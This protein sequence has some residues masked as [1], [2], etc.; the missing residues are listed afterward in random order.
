MNPLISII[1][2]VYNG[3]AY[4]E[5]CFNSILKQTHEN[6]EIIIIND[7]SKDSSPEIC[8]KFAELDNRIKLV[9]QTNRGLSSVRNKGIEMAS[10]DLIGF[11]DSDD[12]I[13]PNMYE[14]LLNNLRDYEA[15]IA[16]CETTKVYDTNIN[17]HI[18][19][20]NKT[21]RKQQIYTFNQEEAFKNLFNEKNLVT[22]V[23]WNKLYKKEIFK[24]VRYPDGKVHDD[25][26]VIHHI[27]QTAQKFVFT[28][29]ILYYYYHNKYSF[30]NEKYKLSKLD[31]LE[32][33]KDRVLF[34]EKYEYNHLLQKG[35]NNYLHLTIIHY[36][37]VQKHYPL[38]KEVKK[39]LTQEFKTV[40]IKYNDILSMENK[41][42]LR[43]FFVHP[44][45]HNKFIEIRKKLSRIEF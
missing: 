42:E 34:F 2:P 21:I 1:V 24:H 5:K 33:I 43:L 3:E 16:M 35:I 27:I 29:A 10:G 39:K 4:I 25:E 36:Y 26:F 41:K 20:S 8:D 23:P 32:A 40:F 37:L 14:M 11:V 30:T 12:S 13:H 19:E 6:L 9:H 38:E 44:I 18:K 28:D 31:A 15:D 7:G 22:V 17:E 45:L